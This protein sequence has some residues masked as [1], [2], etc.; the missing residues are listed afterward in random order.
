ML[1][2]KRSTRHLFSIRYFADRNKELLDHVDATLKNS[3]VQ[4]KHSLSITSRS[5]E[6][7]RTVKQTLEHSERIRMRASSSRGTLFSDSFIR[8]SYKQ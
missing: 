2:G 8:F 3:R 1:S 6:I 4:M 5:L 7:I